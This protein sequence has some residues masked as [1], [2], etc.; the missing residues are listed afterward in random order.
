MTRATGIVQQKE[1]E[2]TIILKNYLSYDLTLSSWEM[3]Y[4]TNKFCSNNFQRIL[5][6]FYSIFYQQLTRLIYF[7]K[8]KTRLTYKIQILHFN[9]F[10]VKFYIKQHYA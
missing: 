1:R 10:C 4:K 5:V 6:T 9:L 8:K 7:V 2:A 3:R